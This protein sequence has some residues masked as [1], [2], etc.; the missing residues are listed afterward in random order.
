MRLVPR[1][2]IGDPLAAL[3]RGKG[4]DQ[5]VGRAHQAFFHR[6]RR[7]DRNE[8]IHQGL[9]ETASKLGQGFGQNKVILGAG[10]LHFFEATGIHDCHVSAQAFADGF[11]R[12]APFVFEQLQREQDARRDRAAATMGAFGEAAG[13]ALLNGCDQLGPGTRIGPPTDGIGFG[14]DIGNLEA[15]SATAEPMLKVA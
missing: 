5:E 10:D 7:L 15:G 3:F 9:V 8:F 13:N 12:G 1:G 2:G 14:D 11:I 6:S 4:V